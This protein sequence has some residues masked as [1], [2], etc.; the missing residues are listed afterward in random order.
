L[1][2]YGLGVLPVNWF[3]IVFI[4]LAFVLFILDIQ[5]T[6][7][8][9]L[10]AAAVGSLIV[11]ALVLFNS[12]GSLPYLRVSVPLVIGTSAVLGGAFFALLV[13]ALR[14]RRLPAAMGAASLVGK[15]GEVKQTLA[16][17]GIVQ[18][19]SE[20]WSAETDGETIEAGQSVVV[21]EV[22]G[23]RL[24]VRRKA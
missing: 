6:S 16:P 18:L 8:G 15:V 5:A 4:V 7:H 24:K 21:V 13:F 3:G 14:T 19:E 1:A 17:K 20:E 22:R 23:V 11:G 9:A 10:T 12:P 2:F